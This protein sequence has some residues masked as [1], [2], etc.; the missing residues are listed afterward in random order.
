M[1]KQTPNLPAFV[2]LSP[3]FKAISALILASFLFGATFV[4]VKSAIASI[5]PISFVAWRFVLGAFVLLV[6]TVPRGKQIWRDGSIAGIALFAGYALQTGGLAFTSATNSALITGLFV[7][8]TPFLAAAFHRYR[9]SPWSV[10]AAVIA[11]VG[12][13]LVTGAEN[14]SLGGG[15]LLT[16]GCALAF[17]VHVVALSIFAP[18]HPVIPL[19]AVQLT[20][21]ALGSIPLAA[22]LDGF[23]WP[24]RSVWPAIIVT[25][26]A[27]SVGAYVLQAWAQNVVG[28]STTAV[29]LALEPA[30]GVATAWVVL[31]DR[32]DLRGWVGATMILV[33]IVVVIRRQKDPASIQAEAVTPAH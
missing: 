10:G 7:V 9:P 4:I 22:L 5:G 2:R 28:A 13:F 24:A 25:G 14:L 27:V 30:F 33:A 20:I 6:I 11:F 26:L 12:L 21:V 16:L 32:L 19:T 1:R 15:D 18:R 23:A 29:V 3:E 17:A 8:L 31:D